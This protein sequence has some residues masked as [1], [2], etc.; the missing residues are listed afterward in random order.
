MSNVGFYPTTHTNNTFF[1]ANVVG[2]VELDGMEFVD[3]YDPVLSYL[4]DSFGPRDIERIYMGQP[5]PNFVAREYGT[6]SLSCLVAM[7][8]QIT[9]VMT[10]PNGTIIK[11]PHVEDIHKFFAWLEKRKAVQKATEIVRL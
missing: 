10:V 11:F 8:N 6:T 1:M 4:L 9:D 5:W 2:T 7:Y 3:Y